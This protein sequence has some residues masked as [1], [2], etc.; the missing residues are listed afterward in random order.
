MKK[1]LLINLNLQL[2]KKHTLIPGVSRCIQD[3]RDHMKSSVTMDEIEFVIKKFQ[4]YISQDRD[5]F[6]GKFYQTFKE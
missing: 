5:S 2:K 4:K 1:F 3:E 6:T